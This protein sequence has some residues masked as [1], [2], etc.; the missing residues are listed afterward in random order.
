MRTREGEGA[1][2][3]TEMGCS[4]QGTG[5]GGEGRRRLRW[6]FSATLVQQQVGER[7]IRR[8]QVESWELLVGDGELDRVLEWER[9]CL[10]GR[11]Q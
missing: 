2:R 1:R 3:G 4:P 5:S 9:C 8:E 6:L 7:R 10:G 11:V